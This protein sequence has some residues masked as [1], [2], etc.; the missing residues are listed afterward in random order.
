MRK[1]WLF[2]LG[3]GMWEV[4]WRCCGCT[5][6]EVPCKGVEG[7]EQEAWWGNWETRSRANTVGIRDK[8]SSIKII[9]SLKAAFILAFSVVPKLIPFLLKSVGVG[10][11]ST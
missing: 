4:G 1:D 6:L 5:C 2:S 9:R 11:P 3:T 7:Q 8:L 10:L